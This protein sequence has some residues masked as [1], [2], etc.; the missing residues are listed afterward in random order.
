MSGVYL[1]VFW[2]CLLRGP[3]QSRLMERRAQA[4]QEAIRD[5]SLEAHPPL[6]WPANAIP[7]TISWNRLP[8]WILIPQIYRSTL[9]PQRRSLSCMAIF[10]QAKLCCSKSGSL[11]AVLAQSYR[12]D[13]AL[14]SCRNMTGRD[15][16]LI[17]HARHPSEATWGITPPIHYVLTHEITDVAAGQPRIYLLPTSRDSSFALVALGRDACHMTWTWDA[18]K[19]P[20]I[21]WSSEEGL[22]CPWD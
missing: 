13:S 8:A 9:T 6:A 2:W 3:V 15:L 22:L 11:V 18:L 14:R 17:G 21:C 19:S 10:T 4:Y 20:R 12:E 5:P 16:A 1:P 7:N